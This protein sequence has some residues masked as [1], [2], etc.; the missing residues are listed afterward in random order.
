MTYNDPITFRP[1]NDDLATLARIRSW[2]AEYY[3]L[4]ASTDAL[5]IR[6]ALSAWAA[7]HPS[8]IPEPDEDYPLA[9]L[10]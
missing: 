7:L 9:G 5:A 6:A 4:A 8:P 1:S 3:P 2:L 10:A